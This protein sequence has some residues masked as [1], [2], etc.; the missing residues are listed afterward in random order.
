[1]ILLILTAHSAENRSQ[2][3]SPLFTLSK[4][5][6]NVVRPSTLEVLD[7][8][9]SS[10]KSSLLESPFG[11][12]K[13]KSSIT[14]IS[15]VLRYSPGFIPLLREFREDVIADVKLSFSNILTSLN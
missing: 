10:Y 9:I 15:V 12:L 8:R 13:S 3:I 6:L 2:L 11:T 14:S 1:M 4:S 5:C 7:L